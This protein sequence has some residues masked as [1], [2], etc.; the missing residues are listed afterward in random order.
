M[1][2][3][4]GNAVRDETG[5]GHNGQA[6]DQDKYEVRIQNWY[7]SPKGWYIIRANDAEIRE[8]IAY[9]MKRA[10]DND[11]IGYDKSDRYTAYNWCKKHNNYDPG[12]ITEPVEVDCSA[13]VRLCCAYAGV[14]VSDFYTGNEVSILKATGKFTVITDTA[15]TN[16][17]DYVRRGDI[18]VTRTVGHTAV[19]LDNGPKAEIDEP[20]VIGIATAKGSIYVRDT[21][22][23][24]GKSLGIVKKGEQVNVIEICTN[25]WYKIIWKDG[26]GY[27][28]NVNDRYYTFSNIY[29][30]IKYIATGNV[31]IR[32]GPA[33]T[34]ATNGVIKRNEV[35]E[36]D[37]IMNNWGRLADGRGYS[38]MKYLRKV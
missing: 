38:S 17:S 2:V 21:N 12:A 37:S 25:S 36:I 24:N 18:I 26:Y 1:A 8:K 20:R 15:I 34:Y 31:Y 14:F 13:L 11:N 32:K 6:G 22:S 30:K 28:S 3:K 27:T 19:I 7:L 35:V 5:N 23:S 29:E 16:T 33:I 9:A 4:I 10:C